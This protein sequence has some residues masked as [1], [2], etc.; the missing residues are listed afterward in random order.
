MHDGEIKTIIEKVKDWLYDNFRDYTHSSD[1][2]DYIT[3]EADFE[4]FEEMMDDFN[5]KMEEY[6]YE[7]S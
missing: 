4:T 2:G 6:K 3:L 5:K 7:K 1:Y